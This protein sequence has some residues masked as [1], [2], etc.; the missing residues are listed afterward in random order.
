[1]R[2]HIYLCQS[3]PSLILY[4]VQ[5]MQRR[6]DCCTYL[7]GSVLLGFARHQ[8]KLIRLYNQAKF[9]SFR[10]HPT[11]KFGIQGPRN[12]TGAEELD[13]KHGNKKWQDAKKPE[14]D[15]IDS[16]STFKDLGKDKRSARLEGYQ[17]P[18]GV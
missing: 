16:Y 10:A 15:Q 2:S 6:M 5:Y 11:Y 17:S 13:K 9:Q 18:D 4:H 1:V 12:H 3:L 8:K 14:L 7:D